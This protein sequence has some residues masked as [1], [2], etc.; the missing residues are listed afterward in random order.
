MDNIIWK[1][2][3]FPIYEYTYS[4]SNMG[5]VIYDLNH[6]PVDR[7]YRS[8][9]GYDFIL[10]ILDPKIKNIC[11]E[12]YKSK[13]MLFRL[14]MLIA[15]A[16]I[17]IPDE[18][19]GKMLDVRHI[20]GDTHNCALDN[21][22]WV[23]DIEIW[24]PLVYPGIKNGIYEVSNHGNVRN[25]KTNNF[26]RTYIDQYGYASIELSAYD[27]N[28]GH[29]SF[30]VHKLIASAFYGYDDEAVV[31]HINGFKLCCDVKNL[32][33]VSS[34]ENMRHASLCGLIKSKRQ[35]YTRLSVDTLDMV[36]DLLFKH[37]GLVTKAYDDI[38]HEKYPSINPGIIYAI[39]TGKNSYSKTNKYTSDELKIL[40]SYKNPKGRKNI[41]QSELD[42]VKK[43]LIKY[44]GNV[45]LV[46]Q[47]PQCKISIAYVYKLKNKMK[48]VEYKSEEITQRNNE[49]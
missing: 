44:N 14:D 3:K 29:K 13:M 11:P 19:V 31:N 20:D 23:E 40:A 49:G 45:R 37:K 2:L 34:S 26:L 4:I 9:N 17:Q 46:T 42:V 30:K 25:I 21:L 43:L 41:P 5:Q 1:P 8:S 32:E 39:K 35:R 36:R 18:L 12:M 22:E 28:L 15:K 10:L 47:D 33:Y 48:P 24:K 6:C 7:I 27:T 38:D 16:F